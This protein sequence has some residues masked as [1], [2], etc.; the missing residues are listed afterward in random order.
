MYGVAGRSWVSMGDPVGLQDEATELA[1]HFHE[2]ADRHHG[3]TCFYQV[4]PAALPRY[5]DMGL[6]LLKLGEEATVPLA[7]FRMDTPDYRG[8][9]HTCRKLEKEGFTFEV[10]PR[11]GVLAL[12]P[13]LEALSHAWMR[14]K[15]TREKGFALG[16]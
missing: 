2:L 11:E 1:W 12:L 16:P 5:L 10:V 6:A 13:E 7:G 15:R 14:Q 9:R 4:G 8:F 3:W